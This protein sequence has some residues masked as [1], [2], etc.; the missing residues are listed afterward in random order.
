[1]NLLAWS[2]DETTGPSCKAEV[3]GRSL[4]RFFAHYF[5]RELMTFC[6][7]RRKD[8]SR[9]IP[10]RSG[11]AQAMVNCLERLGFPIRVIDDPVEPA[12][13]TLTVQGCSGK[14]PN[15]GTL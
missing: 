7:D 4:E 14:I 11:D 12:N 8:T 13:R 15:A 5:V 6:N 3:G 2:D 9:K 1:M 10:A